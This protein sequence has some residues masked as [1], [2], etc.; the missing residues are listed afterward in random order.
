VS[1]GGV[2]DQILEAMTSPVA[3]VTSR[4]D[5][6]LN[7]MT[8]AWMC[9]VS[10]SPVMIAVSIAPERYTHELIIA[11]KVFAVNL[12]SEDQAH[13]GRHFG[14]GTGR[15]NDR[16]SGIDHNACETGAPILND[17]YGYIDC[18]L[19]STF[20]AGDHT[21]FIGEVLKISFDER[22]RPLIF[23]TKDFF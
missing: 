7:G 12:L 16:F 9:Q 11:G 6:N 1:T 2:T 4:S 21:L 14:F 19:V 5:G 15:G 17:C 23:N 13:L 18:K 3:V 20:N 8:A 22:K 10:Y